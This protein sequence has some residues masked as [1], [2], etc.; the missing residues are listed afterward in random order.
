MASA[1]AIV[2]GL[3]LETFLGSSEADR[4]GALLA[5]F[6]VRDS[7]L[8]GDLLDEG[9]LD[10]LESLLRNAGSSFTPEVH[11]IVGRTFSSY[12]EGATTRER[13]TLQDGL[14][15]VLVGPS[16]RTASH[17]EN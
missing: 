9:V 8:I 11:A 14:A 5:V 1:E 12:A 10:A 4:E 13:M 7:V 16:A 17:S 15:S 3:E 2:E 6:M